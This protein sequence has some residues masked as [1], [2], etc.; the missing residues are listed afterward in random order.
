M[1][2]SLTYTSSIVQGSS[3]FSVLL[4]Q[5]R[6]NTHIYYTTMFE[7]VV[8]FPDIDQTMNGLKLIILINH[9]K[10]PNSECASFTNLKM[11]KRKET[12]NTT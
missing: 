11:A 2:K 1:E 8:T 12:C 3:Q 4:E 9:H 7:K 10:N 5:S 6:T